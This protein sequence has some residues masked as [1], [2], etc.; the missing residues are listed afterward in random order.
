MGGGISQHEHTMNKNQH[1]CFKFICLFW[2]L[3]PFD[4]FRFDKNSLISVCA[5]CVFEKCK[6]WNP[7]SICVMYNFPC[8]RFA[9][10]MPAHTF[11]FHNAFWLQPQQTSQP[12]QNNYQHVLRLLSGKSN[13]ENSTIKI[14]NDKRIIPR[15]RY[16]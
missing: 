13:R 10:W 8:F 2:I 12:F 16:F 1:Q 7:I 6:T 4:N 5:I 14:T 9:I 15:M 11:N 3:I